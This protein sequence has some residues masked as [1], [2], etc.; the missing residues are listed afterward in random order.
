M[1]AASR[2][3][4]AAT[5]L[6][7][8]IPVDELAKYAGLT[9]IASAVLA[10]AGILSTVAYLS[11]WGVPAPVVR[12]DPLT[13]A[14][15]SETVVYQFA[16]LAALV[17]GLR[18][19]AGRIEQGARAARLLAVVVTS[20]LVL[21]VAEAIAGGYAGPVITIAGG[22]ALFAAHRRSTMSPR[23]TLIAFALVALVSAYQTGT[24]SGR[25]IRDETAWQTPVVLTTRTAV[26]GL[27]G[28]EAGGGWRYEGVYLVFRDGE[29]L[30]VSRPG[31]GAQVWIVPA[32]NVMG[33]GVG[34]R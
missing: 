5:T 4:P 19:V 21:L 24:E 30:Y 29:A 31:A 27:D 7:L 25:I 9:A 26:G 1:T 13:A 12:F 14:L 15:R 2:V 18:A 10:G 20:V 8:R 32:A 22:V 17:F 34:A 28:T 3:E 6:A 11:A 23:S 33:L 16:L